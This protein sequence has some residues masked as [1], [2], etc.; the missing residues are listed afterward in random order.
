MKDVTDHQPPVKNFPI[1]VF[2]DHPDMISIKDY[3]SLQQHPHFKESIPRDTSKLDSLVG[4]YRSPQK[5]KCAFGHPHMRG[6]L[7]RLNDE[8]LTLLGHN[9]GENHFDVRDY[10]RSKNAF[11]AL[12]DRE[13][14]KRR[15]ASLEFL[16]RRFQSLFSSALPLFRAAQKLCSEMP[17]QAKLQIDRM[18]RDKDSRIVLLSSADGRERDI[19]K[20]LQ[21]RHSD[22]NLEVIGVL[23][24]IECL[25]QRYNVFQL[26]KQSKELIA[27]LQGETAYSTVFERKSVRQRLDKLE[28][29]LRQIEKAERYLHAFLASDNLNQ[30]S[31]CVDGS[32]KKKQ[33][34]LLVSKWSMEHRFK[35]A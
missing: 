17:A 7:V 23:Q 20:I 9:C 8:T 1:D 10:I 33:I 18:R 34:K 2:S 22:L 15:L 13:L 5:V 32:G 21:N 35:A 16:E 25:E 12:R 26:L 14:L 3:E 27:S 11:T 6:Y 31:K 24:G 4:E 30:L 28:A 19:N 29:G